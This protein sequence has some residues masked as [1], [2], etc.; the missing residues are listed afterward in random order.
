MRLWKAKGC[1][2]CNHTGYHG[3]AAIFEVLAVDEDIQKL[4]RTGVNAGAIAAAAK[5]GGMTTMIVDG[6][7]KCESGLTTVAEV[8]RVAL[9][10]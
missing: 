4:I 9:E 10:L 3:R 6:L 1:E 8:S 2:H 5:Q 7:A